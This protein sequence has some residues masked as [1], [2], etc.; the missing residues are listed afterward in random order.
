MS[1]STLLHRDAS[2]TVVPAR[3]LRAMD[4][5][6]RAYDRLADA[7]ET[8]QFSLHPRTGRLTITLADLDGHPQAEVSPRAVLDVAAGGDLDAVAA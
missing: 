6:A 8:L 7:G 2:L 1:S 4:V 5:A 3:V